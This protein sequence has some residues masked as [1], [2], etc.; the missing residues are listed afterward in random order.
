[1][2][3]DKV[4]TFSK[5]GFSYLQMQG[6]IDPAFGFSLGDIVIQALFNRKER[7]G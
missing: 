3:L 4:V 2:T 1:M 5:L 7:C 6:F